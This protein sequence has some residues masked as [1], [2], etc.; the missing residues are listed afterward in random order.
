MEPN[1]DELLIRWTAGITGVLDP[2]ND[3]EEETNDGG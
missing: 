2:I 1:L 3:H